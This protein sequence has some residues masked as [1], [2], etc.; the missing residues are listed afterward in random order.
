M[1]TL[2]VLMAVLLTSSLS[3]GQSGVAFETAQHLQEACKG[4]P[5][6]NRS[7]NYR[8]QWGYCL[9]Y[10]TAQFDTDNFGKAEY[11]TSA[12]LHPDQLVWAVNK[13]LTDELRA[14]PEKADTPAF[15]LV[16]SA[17]LK[18]FPLR[19]NSGK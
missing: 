10:V 8:V 15:F 17:F 3:Q 5:F 12:V 11:D 14:H 4:Y 19:R 16:R 2:G 9:G 6:D 1:K 7:A 13:Y 18:A